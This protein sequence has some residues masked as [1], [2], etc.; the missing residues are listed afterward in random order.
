[1]EKKKKEKRRSN[2]MIHKLHMKAFDFFFFGGI[3]RF[4]FVSSILGY[5]GNFF[6]PNPFSN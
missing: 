4:V 3:L 5:G 6:F 2:I 1:M